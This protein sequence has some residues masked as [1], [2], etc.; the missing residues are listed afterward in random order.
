VSPIAAA[1]R[2]HLLSGEPAGRRSPRAG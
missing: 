2:E 1:F